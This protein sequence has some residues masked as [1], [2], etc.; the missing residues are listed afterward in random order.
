MLSQLIAS[1]IERGFMGSEIV[2]ETKMWEAVSNRDADADGRF[3]FA[4]KSTKIY[5]KPSCASRRPLRERVEFFESPDRAETRDIAP[6]FAV[7][8]AK[9]GRVTHRLRW[10]R[11]H[12]GCWKASRRHRLVLRSFQ[13]SWG[14][15]RTIFNVRSGRSWVSAQDNM[16]KVGEWN[17]LRSE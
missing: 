17:S 9:Q 10:S 1:D 2:S 11:R 13:G 14:A 7:S 16:P 6:V 5:C 4:V 8:H 15:V 3:V 12:A